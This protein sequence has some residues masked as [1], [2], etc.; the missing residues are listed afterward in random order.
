[1]R[2]FEDKDKSNMWERRLMKILLEKSTTYERLE[3]NMHRID[4]LMYAYE[5]P[6]L[7]HEISTAL[8]T[9]KPGTREIAEHVL[10][11]NPLDKQIFNMIQ[12]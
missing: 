4:L 9:G 5:R 2:G 7:I 3:E 10:R 6:R 1:M 12:P 8:E 11:G